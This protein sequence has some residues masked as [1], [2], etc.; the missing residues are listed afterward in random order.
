MIPY[1]EFHASKEINVE[2]NSRPSLNTR[3]KVWLS[4][5]RFSLKSKHSWL[6]V[7]EF[8]CRVC[9]EIWKSRVEIR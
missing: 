2:I 1:A 8:G 3:S 5:L 7:S 6:P 9:Q 4:L